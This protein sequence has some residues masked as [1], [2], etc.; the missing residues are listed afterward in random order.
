MRFEVGGLGEFFVAPVEWTDVGTISSVNPDVCSEVEIEREPLAA[1]LEGALERLLSCVD[2]LVPLQLGALDKGFAALG[3]DVDSWSVGV[4]VLPHCRI[5]PE[6]FGAAFVRTRN[7]ARHL[8][9]GLSLGLDSG[10]EK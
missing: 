6:H 1:A 10:G 3:A 5:V 9:T 4:K 8:F 7:R 2:E